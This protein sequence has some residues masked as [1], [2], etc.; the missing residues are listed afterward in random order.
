MYLNVVEFDGNRRNTDINLKCVITLAD[1]MAASVSESPVH[2]ILDPP[3][4]K[5][6]FLLMF[7]TLHVVPSDIDCLPEYEQVHKL[8]K[9]LQ[10]F[11][12]KKYNLSFGYK[13]NDGYFGIDWDKRLQA[14]IEGYDA[15][16]VS[17]TNLEYQSTSLAM[18]RKIIEDKFKKGFTKDVVKFISE[19]TS[20]SAQKPQILKI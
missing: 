4:Q 8:V 3:S 14:D 7:D 13:F 5:Y 6:L 20:K 11:L 10:S 18:I 16:D 17:S 19:N 12:E 15:I 2:K 1:Y 9:N